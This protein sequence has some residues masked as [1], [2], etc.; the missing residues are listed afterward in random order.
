MRDRTGIVHTVCWNIPYVLREVLYVWKL[1]KGESRGNIGNLFYDEKVLFLP[2]NCQKW[3]TYTWKVI[4]FII[5]N[6]FLSDF[7]LSKNFMLLIVWNTR[8]L[9]DS[10]LF[11]PDQLFCQ[12]II[13]NLTKI[14]RLSVYRIR[15]K[16]N[17]NDYWNVI[18]L[19]FFKT[20]AYT[21]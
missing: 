6:F 14:I 10:L 20:I 1:F 13:I 17:H 12:S 18:K 19:S 2:L 11:L 8:M 5:Q 3:L 16:K 4:K 21:R 9:L 7:I 15:K